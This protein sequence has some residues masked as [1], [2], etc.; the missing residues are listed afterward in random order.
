MSFRRSMSYASSIDDLGTPVTDIPYCLSTARLPHIN[1]AFWDSLLT[2]LRSPS[3]HKNHRKQS[4]TG[5]LFPPCGQSPKD[6]D[7]RDIDTGEYITTQ[8][9]I[10]LLLAPILIH[11]LLESDISI[12]ENSSPK[13]ISSHNS[14]CGLGAIP[15]TFTSFVPGPKQ[16]TQRETMSGDPNQQPRASAAELQYGHSGKEREPDNQPQGPSYQQSGDPATAYLRFGPKPSPAAAAEQHGPGG[17]ERKPDT[18]GH[19]PSD[20]RFYKPSAAAEKFGS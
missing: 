16:N 12:P 18:Y 7:L 10:C 14:N 3:T 8:R 6:L 2:L 4:T 9:L 19:G 20:K 1:T 17:Q 13:S 5:R 15:D 11:V